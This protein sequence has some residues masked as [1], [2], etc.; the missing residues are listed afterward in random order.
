M[1]IVDKLLKEATRSGRLE[2]KISRCQ[3]TKIESKFVEKTVNTDVDKKQDSSKIKNQ[4]N[5]LQRHEP[6][7]RT[8]A[9]EATVQSV[10]GKNGCWSDGVQ[11]EAF[12]FRQAQG[13]SNG[14]L[15]R[16]IDQPDLSGRMI[17]RRN[18]SQDSTELNYFKLAALCSSPSTKDRNES[19]IFRFDKN[20]QDINNHWLIKETEHMRLTDQLKNERDQEMRYN[21]NSATNDEP[22]SKNTL[23]KTRCNGTKI[24]ERSKSESN[25]NNLR[26]GSYETDSEDQDGVVTLSEQQNCSHCGQLL[27]HG[28]A[29][30]IESLQLYFHITCFRCYVCQAALGDGSRG[31]DVRVKQ[32]KLHCQE[33]Y[34]GGANNGGTNDVFIDLQICS[35]TIHIVMCG[36]ISPSIT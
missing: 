9:I 18:D 14:I 24:D 28:A 21:G 19:S 29:M 8:P 5:G 30:T 20:N 35:R 10:L 3:K 31:T 22:K 15:S 13:L 1:D 36:R 6:I 17:H 34:N 12:A 25:N 23:L 26:T 2:L 27:G 16:N 11:D 33:C 4:T 32:G 7:I